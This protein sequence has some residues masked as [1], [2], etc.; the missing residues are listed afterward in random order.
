M[1]TICSGNTHPVKIPPEAA[2]QSLWKSLLGA[3]SAISDTACSQ[4]HKSAVLT[5]E[6]YSSWI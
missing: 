6:D 1:R 5:D 2:C 4:E 3:V